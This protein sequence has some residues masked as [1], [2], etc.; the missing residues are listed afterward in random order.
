MK[1]IYIIALVFFISHAAQAQQFLN[2]S[3]EN[4]TAGTCQWNLSNTAFN[5]F[6]PH[7]FGFGAMNEL[8]IHRVG[9]NYGAPTTQGEYF[10]SL[11]HSP[12]TN[13][14][15]VSVFIDTA[16]V[17]GTTYTFNFY[18][19]CDITFDP[20]DS[21]T[22][23]VSTDS[24]LFGTLIYSCLPPIGSWVMHSVTFTSPAAA[25]FITFQNGGTQE[26]WNFI[27]G[28]SFL[29]TGID[30][31]TNADVQIFPSAA[32]D[33]IYIKGIAAAEIYIVDIAGRIC[34]QQKVNGQSEINISQLSKGTYFLLIQEKE[35]LLRKKFTKL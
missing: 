20:N 23:G 32:T 18:T 26:A 15:A 30:E 5:S 29:Q 9:C 2:G 22:V 27:D 4:N 7:T 19:S 1:K 35:N 17:P 8:D 31:A 25:R 21:L 16:L 34:M 10:I 13:Y 6:M 3:F 28:L 12:P 33:K 14:D 24:S 11:H